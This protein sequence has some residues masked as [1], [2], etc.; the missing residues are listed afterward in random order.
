MKRR[1]RMK[2]TRK[3]I[4]MLMTL[5]MILSLESGVTMPRKARAAGYG[6]KNPTNTKEDGSG[7]TT[8]DCIYFG[9][10]WQNDTNGDGIADEDDKK[11]PIKWRVLSVN[12]EDAFLLADQNLDVKPY[13]TYYTKKMHWET[14]TLRKWLNGY[15]ES[16]TNEGNDNFIDNAFNDL[17]QDAIL[18]DDGTNDKISLMSRGDVAN[19]SYGFNETFDVKSDTRVSTATSYTAR[20]RNISGACSWVLC[21]ISYVDRDGDTTM[22]VGANGMGHDCS[23]NVS[24]SNCVRPILHLNLSRSELWKYAGTVSSDEWRIPEPSPKKV[25]TTKITATAYNSDS[26]VPLEGVKI[27]IEDL[28]D[29]STDSRGNAMMENTQ[30]EPSILRKVTAKKDGYR[31]YIYYT[32]IISPDVIDLSYTEI[33][34]LNIPMCKSKDNDN[35]TPYVSSVV[36]YLNG[37][38]ENCGGQQF[39]KSD[40]VKFRVCGVWN[41]KTPDHYCLYQEGG[42]TFRSTD[43][44]FELNIGMSFKEQDKIYAKMVAKDGTESEPQRVNICVVADNMDDDA[45]KYISVLNNPAKSEI[46]KDVPFLDGSG[47]DFDIGKLKC[48]Y[49]CQDKKIRIRLGSEAE[50]SEDIFNDEKWK[51]WKKFCESQPEDLTVSQWADILKSKNMTSSVTH[52][53]NMKLT[54]YGW[55]EGDCNNNTTTPLTGGI[56]VIM[57]VGTNFSQQYLIGTIPVYMEEGLKIDGE[58]VGN[59]TYDFQD[60]KLRGDNKLTISPSLSVGGGVG[61]LY[62]ATV[63]AEGSASMPMEINVPKGMTSAKLSGSLSLKAS[64]LGFQYSKDFAQKEFVLFE[65]NVNGLRGASGKKTSRQISMYDMDSYELPEET[66]EPTVWYGD[67]KNKKLRKGIGTADNLK[68]QLL[69]TGTSE[70]TEPVLVSEGGTTMAVFLTEDAQ[71]ETIHRT[72]LVYTVYDPET[73]LW[74]EPEAVEDDETGDLL[75]YLTAANGKIA[76][77]WMNYDSSV[78]DSSS[79]EDAL[80]SSFLCYAVWNPETARF[81]VSSDTLASDADTTYN[82]VRPLIDQDGNV[83]RIGLKNTAADIFGTDGNN[84]LFMEGTHDQQNISKEITVTQG[85]PVSYDVAE[86]GDG[87]RAAICVDTDRDMTTMEDREIYVYSSDGTV[88]CVTEENVYDGAPKYARY[89]GKTALYWYSGDG[90]HILDEQ[91]EETVIPKEISDQISENFDVVSNNEGKTAIVYSSA[92]EDGT[93]QLSALLYDEDRNVWTTQVILTDSGEDIFRANGYFNEQGDMEFIYRKGSTADTGALYALRAETAPDVEIV[94]A[95]LEDG[96]EVPGQNTT[97]YVG[98]RNNGTEKIRN[99]SVEADGQV[100]S[101]SAVILPGESTLLEVPYTVPDQVESREVEVSVQVDGDCNTSNN[102]FTMDAGYTDL[103]LA[104]SEDRTDAGKRVTVIVENQEAVEADATLEVHEDSETGTLVSTQKLGTMKQGEKVSVSF[105]YKNKIVGDTD[106]EHL[107]YV[108]KS[109]KKE[110]YTSNNVDYVILPESPEKDIEPSPSVSPSENPEGTSSPNPTLNPTKATTVTPTAKPIQKPSVTPTVKPTQ[111]PTVAPTAKPAGKPSSTPKVK[112]T[113]APDTNASAVPDSPM[114]APS[115]AQA[116]SSQSPAGT[117]QPSGSSIPVSTFRP[118]STGTLSP[119]ASGGSG[120]TAAASSSL[121]TTVS[122]S[123]AP[124]ATQTFY[125]GQ[126]FKDVKTKAYYKILSVTATGGKAA[127]L[128]PV[129]KKVKKVTIKETVTFKGKR[130]KITQIGNKAFKDYK[131]LQKITIGRKVSVIGKKTFANCRSLKVVI[132]TGPKQKLPKNAFAG[133]PRKPKVRKTY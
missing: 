26:F 28:G 121:K 6:L 96:T 24:Q 32:T 84:I 104:V 71:R 102:S 35:V 80:S 127:Y 118:G 62:V 31:D 100:T 5:A 48:S 57:N 103:A 113:K 132:L 38:T 10:Y 52:N 119:S 15:G 53:I 44:T 45:E 94:N 39:Q 61:V 91:G 87:V 56:Q 13:N 85:I 116:S 18:D 27:F 29:M 69:E 46:L 14:C 109:D 54:G 110:K 129:D 40:I 128:R 50:Y 12:G 123:K 133:C 93:Y 9:H 59:V 77:S 86:D 30:R 125:K 43:G 23:K 2:N 20:K 8:W 58:F 95:Y 55:L 107:Y 124:A 130:F 68:E 47:L 90:Y 22:D 89:C 83:T 33:N 82:S 98:V 99:Y 115:N 70:L 108:V 111:K 126:V 97:L 122:A 81:E 4:A 36:Y 64:V 21:Q 67:K 106:A 66:A 79:M 78:D 60:K 120:I 34:Q 1:K 75:P 11:Q 49:S 73:S 51:E 65:K 117:Q 101:G 25:D 3:S 7:V 131:K 92:Q 17:E 19:V 76:V 42:E 112:P 105:I 37:R 114:P 41:D 88:T 63:G 16:D 72:K 74:S